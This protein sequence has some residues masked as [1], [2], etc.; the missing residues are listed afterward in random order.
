M[1]PKSKSK[2]HAKT[3]I[4]YFSLELSYECPNAEVAVSAGVFACRLDKG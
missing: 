3:V 4:L 2:F 1:S